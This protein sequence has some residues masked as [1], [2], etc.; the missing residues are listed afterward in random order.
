MVCCFWW[1]V[2]SENSI[3]SRVLLVPDNCGLQ[4]HLA[5]PT[6]RLQVGQRTF[7]S[8]AGVASALAD[9]PEFLVVVEKVEELEE[10]EEREEREGREV[11]EVR[12]VESEPF[13]SLV[14]FS[15]LFLMCGGT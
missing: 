9:A 10:L 14:F 8:S 3:S 4:K 2:L 5:L 12:E 1:W 7:F 11:R 13:L 15:I 6:G